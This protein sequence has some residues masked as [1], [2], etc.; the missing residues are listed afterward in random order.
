MDYLVD[1]IIVG[2]LETNCYI[3]AE[4][5]SKTCAIIDPGADYKKIKKYLDSRDFTPL[6]II[7]THGHGDH[8]MADEEFNLPI[9]IHKDD[10][11]FLHDPGKNL[12]FVYSIKRKADKI[13][14]DGDEIN[15]GNLVI[16][17]IHTPGHTPGGICLLCEDILFSGDTLFASGVGRTDLP[18]ADE[19]K[20]IDSIKTKLFIL[21][22]N[23]KVYPGHGP[24]TTIG[25]EKWQNL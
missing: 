10:A 16:K 25:K 4:E 15:L 11:D 21:N 24:E 7:N 6:F 3:L 20:L 5:T 12:S 13:L 2:E 18:Y 19:A 9:Y 14:M 1:K 22:D 8:I 17:V 23:V